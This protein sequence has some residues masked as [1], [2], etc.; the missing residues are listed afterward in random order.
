MNQLQPEPINLRTGIIDSSR[1]RQFCQLSPGKAVPA[2]PPPAAQRRVG[3]GRDCLKT[4]Y[5]P[6]GLGEMLKSQQFMWK[7]FKNVET[8][9]VHAVSMP[10]GMSPHG[11]AMNWSL[12]ETAEPLTCHLCL[13]FAFQGRFQSAEL[14]AMLPSGFDGCGGAER[15]CSLCHVPLSRCCC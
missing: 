1:L 4:S 14:H 8:G 7:A 2:M 12:V 6:M 15:R 9:V 3:V 11:F 5:A 13:Q 10:R